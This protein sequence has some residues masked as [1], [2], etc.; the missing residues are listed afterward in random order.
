MAI[1]KLE[2]MRLYNPSIKI[3]FI[4]ENYDDNEDTRKNIGYTFQKCNEYERVVEKDVALLTKS[5]FEILFIEH[6]KFRNH[7]SLNSISIIGKYQEWC[8]SELKI[9][10][11]YNIHDF[12]IEEK[13]KFIS[14]MKYISRYQLLS[15]LNDQNL[16]SRN[17]SILFLAFEGVNGREHYE[18]R[19]LKIY[20][21]I[22]NKINI[23]GDRART[24]SIPTKLIELLYEADKLTEMDRNVKDPN[25]KAV[26]SVF[27]DN[28]FIIRNT[29]KSRKPLGKQMVNN[30]ISDILNEFYGYPIENAVKFISYSG[31][32]D[33]FK[34]IRSELLI[35]GPKISKDIYEKISYRYG[36]NKTLWFDE[37]K[38]ILNNDNDEILYNDSDQM[39]IINAILDSIPNNFTDEK[40]KKD[41]TINDEDEDEDN[42]QNDEEKE[43]PGWLQFCGKLGA[44]G[45]KLAEQMLKLQFDSVHDVHKNYRLGYDFK[46]YDKSQN[47]YYF[48]VKTSFRERFFISSNELEKA[49]RFKDRYN[50]LFIHVNNKEKILKSIQINQPIDF[51]EL[52]YDLIT[53]KKDYKKCLLNAKSFSIEMKSSI[54]ENAGL[55]PEG[56][57]EQCRLS[58]ENLLNTKR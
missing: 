29:Q 34:R 9:N 30:I 7:R 38:L 16:N 40:A 48:E 33:W 18:I 20:D 27:Y 14:K 26:K 3:R 28:G 41:I 45:E 25:A 51:F 49:A 54:L 24:I 58:F 19:Y 39:V 1:D 23:P 8:K 6:F 12:S 32:I 56:I 5:Q 15:I 17:K 37:K 47:V 55:I 31:R 35:D 2:N 22:G 57:I 52:E 46:V 4:R 43:T 44:L 42:D 36:V 21:I 50:I 13:H 10:I 11:N 53:K